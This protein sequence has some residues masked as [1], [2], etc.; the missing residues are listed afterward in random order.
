MSARSELDSLLGA[1]SFFTR[2]SNNLCCLLPGLGKHI[3]CIF[4]TLGQ[5]FFVQFVR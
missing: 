2:L 3:I 4:F 5:T 1:I